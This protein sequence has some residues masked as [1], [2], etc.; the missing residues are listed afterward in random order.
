MIEEIRIQNYLSFKEEVVLNFEATKEKTFEE[1]QVVTVAPGVRL[2]R[3]AL[4]YGANAS[5][6]SNLL[7]ALDYLHNFWFASKRDMDETTGVVPFL[8]D[9][10][11]PLK[12]T[13]FSLKFYVNGMRYWYVVQLTSK[14]VIEEK[15]FLYKSVQPS[16]LFSRK[17]LHGQSVVK[18]N[19]AYVK[20]GPN[21]LNELNL[22][23][24]PNMSFFAARNQVNCYLPIIDEAWNWMKKKM[25][26]IIMPQTKMFAYAG[27]Q[28]SQD[29]ELKQYILDFVH[30]ADYN[31]TDVQT[32]KETKP[33]P[34]I[35]RSIVREAADI[36]VKTKENLLA[37]NSIE[38]IRTDFIHTVK[39][40]RGVESYYL[41]QKLQSTGTQRTIEVEAAIYTALHSNGI[42]PID[43]IESSL[44]P[45]LVEFI[46]EMFLKQE[47]QSQLIITSHYDPLLNTVDDLFRRDS[48]WFTEKEEDGHSTV[49]S[50]VDF[51][52]LRKIKSFQK[53]YRNGVFGAIPNIKSNS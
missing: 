49:Y 8:L 30:K 37:E 46:L 34:P 40:S 47:S 19:P 13:C 5:G 32:Q 11:T 9:K 4:I 15:L 1:S 3:F 12:P 41:P 26:P 42:L 2:L 17:K 38:T 10:E 25:Q 53:S 24:L 14:E 23:C 43:E 28:M 7:T 21:V 20:S 22:K 45:D 31:I 52:G 16:L 36:P 27:K 33:L 18:L 6:K 35:L 29:P 48:V 44:H 39:N 50:L 51:K